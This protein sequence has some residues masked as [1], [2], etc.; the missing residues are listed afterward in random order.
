MMLNFYT[1]FHLPEL[2]P[3]SVFLG[4]C[5]YTTFFGCDWLALDEESLSP[6]QPQCQVLSTGSTAQIGTSMVCLEMKG[7]K[8]SWFPAKHIPNFETHPS[9]SNRQMSWE[10]PRDSLLQQEICGKGTD[11]S[12]N[13]K[14]FFPPNK[15]PMPIVESKDYP[16]GN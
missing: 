1:V 9:P 3:F 14:R 4:G 11:D 5:T 6:N 7:K 8:F 10:F 16:S 2:S 15:N 12:L 13:L